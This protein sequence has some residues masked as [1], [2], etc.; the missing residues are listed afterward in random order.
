VGESNWAGNHLFEASRILR[1]RT[2]D[3]VRQLVADAPKVKA[4][5]T[6]H[7]FNDVADFDGGVLIDLADVDTP[8]EIDADASTVTVGAA[9]RYGDFIP[10]LHEAG[11]AL[12][13]LASLPHCSVAGSVATATH[14]SGQRVRNLAAAMSGIE[15]VT[16][17]GGLRRLTR[18]QDPDVFPGLA[19]GLGALGVVTR[20]TLDLVPTFSVRQDAFV[21]IPWSVLL[22]EFDAI[23]ADG[24]SVSLFTPWLGDSAG[25][26]LLKRRA[27]PGEALPELAGFHGGIPMEAPPRDNFTEWGVTGPW[28]ERLPH[29]R[30][31]AV[32][33]V[34]EE[35]QSEY[36]VPIAD[37]AAAL[38]EIR[39]MGESLAP[40]LFVSEIRTV[41]G[42]DL[43][44]S[45]SHG[46]DRVCIHFTWQPKPEAVA[47]LLPRIE[48]RLA[49]FGARPHWGKLFH[50]GPWLAERYP[51][52]PAFRALAERLD[53]TGTFRS[54]FVSRHVFDE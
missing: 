53:P 42:D 14:G 6:R 22:S 37:A 9:V 24:Y 46:G 36:L 51:E 11:F 15:L 18:E 54:P 1:P 26:V 49:P 23:Q 35:L 16:A 39:A 5:G 31:D 17:D 3:E 34:G 27:E 29:F 28:H 50:G 32:P 30:L 8:L 45:P 10:A 21:E 38:A 12:E 44:L 20:L 7:S 43:W 13:N 4:L 33:S 19:V 48:E 40:A 25:M 41:A 52:M 2:V 47:A